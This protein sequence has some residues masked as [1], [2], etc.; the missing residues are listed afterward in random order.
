MMYSIGRLEEEVLDTIGNVF[1]NDEA[2]GT[3]HSH[4]ESIVTGMYCSV[5]SMNISSCSKM[6][7]SGPKKKTDS[8]PKI[9]A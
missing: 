8:N 3:F 6:K 7:I 1:V 4:D 5:K 2:G 9:I